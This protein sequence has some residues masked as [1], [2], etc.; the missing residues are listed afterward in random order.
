MRKAEEEWKLTSSS[1]TMQGGKILWALII[2]L[3][4]SGY[5]YGADEASDEA[6]AN[7]QSFLHVALPSSSLSSYNFSMPLCMW[8]GVRCGGNGVVYGLFLESQGLRGAIPMGTLGKLTSLTH[9]SLYN[10]SL[11]SP[12]PSDL[13]SLSNLE[14]LSLSLNAFDEEVP[15]QLS[16]LGKLQR[17]DLSHNNFHGSL[18]TEISQLRT[19][20]YLYL[21]F[22][23]FSGI[24]PAALFDAGS[25]MVVDLC[26]NKLTGSLSPQLTNL[27]NL[28]YLNLS[29]NSLSGTLPSSLSS[30][31]SLTTLDLSNNSFSGHLTPLNASSLEHVFLSF[32]TFIGAVPVLQSAKV[33]KLNANL[34]YG[35]LQ[36]VFGSQLVE[37]DLHLNVLSGDVS[38]FINSTSPAIK[39]LDLSVNNFSGSL[40][41]VDF[42]LHTALD[43]LDLSFNE[44]EGS[45]PDDIGKASS[46]EYINL[47]N[48]KLTGSIPASVSQLGSLKHLDLSKNSLSGNITQLAGVSSLKYL[49][50][51]Y[52]NGLGCNLALV[53][54]FGQDSFTGLNCK[55]AAAN[56]MVPPMGRG[57]KSR[58]K[59]EVIV[60]IVAGCALAVALLF[61][62]GAVIVCRRRG[63]WPPHST[64]SLKQRA[65]AYKEDSRFMSGPFSFESNS[66]PWAANVKNA[67]SVP[68]IMFEKPLL[69]LSFADLLRAT[70]NFNRETQVSQGGL[71]P[72]YSAVLSGDLHVSIKVL[73]EGR[74][75]TNE[76]AAAEFEAL[77][78]IKH[79]NL[80][81]ILGYC[82]VGEERLVIYEFMRNGGLHRWLLGSPDRSHGLH[83]SSHLYYDISMDLASRA[84]VEPLPEAVN[85]SWPVRHKV[86]LGVARA[87]AFLH[88]GQ[89]VK[90]VHRD[91]KASNVMLDEEFEPHLANTGLAGLLAGSDEALFAGGSPGYAPPEYGQAGGKVTTMGDVFSYGVI[92]LELVTGKKPVGDSYEDEEGVDLGVGFNGRSGINDLVGWVRMLMHEKRPGSLVRALDPRACEDQISE[93]QMLEV[94]R[95]GYL[96][97]AESPS[98]RPTIQQVVGLLKDM[99][100]NITSP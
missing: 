81:P 8:G 61:I 40:S 30:L 51:S 94:L 33:A 18:P 34:L 44:V 90:L 29:V 71:G 67:T 79:P 65:A 32:N 36:Q 24:I 95:I 84:T 38:E 41:Q 54:V 57:S 3:L 68:V 86:A 80:V 15:E 10:N 62:V 20:R 59:W 82:I 23:A 27:A 58:V 25:L 47:C 60:G 13:W 52:N 39:H 7:L 16:Y 88:H 14:Y 43:Y 73:I 75:L 6:G 45:I 64:L 56:I 22:N 69:N 19:L 99:A 91:V 74:V 53:S 9:L 70:S 4:A 96:C 93:G 85:L 46:L 21:G 26:C 63:R 2:C 55:P 42:A 87:L 28:V 5:G 66:G 49:N 92:L 50:L 11:Q 12:I 77:S 100:P 98:K 72:V 78:K 37:L 35:H 31:R 1:V 17:L 83:S 48:N 89:S 76:V 97:T